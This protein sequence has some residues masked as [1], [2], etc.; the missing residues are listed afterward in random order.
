M[1]GVLLVT[2][3]HMGQDL[4]DTVSAMLGRPS[5]PT[6]VIEV[7][8]SDDPERLLPAARATASAL[9]SGDGL[10][11]LTDAFGSTPSNI[12]NQI[13]AQRGYRVVAGVNLPMLVRIY[14]YPDLALDAMVDSAVDGG[15][16]GIIPCTEQQDRSCDE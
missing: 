9:D 2:H 11:L 6:D 16:L 15:Q 1:I 5:L 12:A 10:L 8:R 7:H 3:G 4:V 14:N 13:A